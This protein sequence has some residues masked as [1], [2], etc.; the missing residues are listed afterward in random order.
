MSAPQAIPPGTIVVEA[1]G[2]F[3]AAA[4]Q[5]SHLDL[6]E[7]RK[8]VLTPDGAYRLDLC[9]TPRLPSRMRFDRSAS[10]RFEQPGRL[11]VIP[12]AEPLTVWNHLGRETVLVC[13]LFTGGME[14][15]LDED[16]APSPQALD[17]GLDVSSHPIEQAMLRMVDE[18]RHPGFAAEV[19]VEALAVQVAVEL[20]RQYRQPAARTVSGGLAPWRLRRIEERLRTLDEAPS[21]TELAALCG[22]SVRQL[23]RGFLASR[24]MPIGRY[25][26]QRRTARAKLLLAGDRSV[27]DV[28]G[29][30][31]FASTAAFCAAFRKATGLTPAAYRAAATS[32]G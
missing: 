29:Q 21:L 19:M 11:F 17:A 5:L 16:A 22:L 24:G 10:S 7:S 20:Q 30:L 1:E 31:G 27:K 15:W 23:A 32:R 9:L 6:V 28:A 12:P 2:R 18:V 8:S 13:H 25:V 26:V 4:V 14:R 3:P